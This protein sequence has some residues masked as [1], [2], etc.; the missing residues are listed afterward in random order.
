M[1]LDR[2]IPPWTAL[3]AVGN[4]GALK[5]S[6]AA[7]A[8]V[9]LLTTNDGLREV[10]GLSR[11]VLAA[12]YFGS[13]ALALA[14]LLYD[15]S[16]PAIVRR[17]DSPNDLYREMLAIKAM[18]VAAYPSD[19]FQADLAHCKAA[20]A[21]AGHRAPVRRALTTVLF[22]LAATCTSLLL[23]NRTVTVVRALL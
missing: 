7:F 22:L 23:L 3:R 12:A 15:T 2:H 18:A 9:P 11:W 19:D 21:G 6:Y 16:C 5:A 14:N 20:Y 1:G 10:L 4:V 17:F 8:L 13:L